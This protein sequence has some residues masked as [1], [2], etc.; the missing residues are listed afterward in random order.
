MADLRTS[1]AQRRAVRRF[2]IA[3]DGDRCGRCGLPGARELGHVLPRSRGG[4]DDI[5]N[6][7]LEH[8]ACNRAAGNRPDSPR[9]RLLEPRP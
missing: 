7:R 2:L 1:D 5:S 4:S 8:G 9:A 6:L 3:R